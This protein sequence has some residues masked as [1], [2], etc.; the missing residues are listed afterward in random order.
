MKYYYEW[1]IDKE[2]RNRQKHGISF[3]ESAGIFLDPHAQTIF[4]EE[5]IEREDRWITMGLE[6]NGKLLIVVH[7]FQQVDENFCKI[8]IISARKATR[9]EAG[10]YR[11]DNP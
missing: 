11:E 2:K 6:K 7:T 8:R 10:K 4:D 3:E 1:D 5:H 9:M